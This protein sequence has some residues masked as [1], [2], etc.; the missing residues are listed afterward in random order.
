MTWEEAVIWYKNQPDN[1]INILYNYF[2]DDV[3]EA[4]QRYEASSEFKEILALLEGCEHILDIASGRGITSYA[5]AKNKK[6]VVALE[7]DKSDLVG[8]GSMKILM[9]QSDKKFEIVES[10]CEELPFGDGSF[11]AVFVRQGVHHF[12]DLD[13]S[14]NEIFRVLKEGGKFLA[15]R[16]HVLDKE[17]DLELFLQNHPLH[18]HYGGENAYVLNRYVNAFKNGGFN[19][20]KII[21]PFDSEINLFP[22]SKEQIRINLNKKYKTQIDDEFFKS[23]LERLNSSVKTAGILYSFLCEKG[24]CEC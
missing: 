18:I 15:V 9:S 20:I 19:N 10:Y 14:I 24:F 12:H 6:N 2:D 13:K 8:N 23:E 21:S 1:E 3:L 7:P 5:F 17:E 22:N 11:D 16:E 4:A